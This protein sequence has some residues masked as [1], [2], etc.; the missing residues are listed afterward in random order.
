MA[1]ATGE[2]RRRHNL[3]SSGNQATTAFWSRGSIQL[4]Y[5]TQIMAGFEPASF[6]AIEVTFVFTTGESLPRRYSPKER[7][8]SSCSATAALSWRNPVFLRA[9]SRLMSSAICSNS[10]RAGNVRFV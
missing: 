5:M 3:E 6:G 2:P 10:H 7:D 1:C 8:S 9:G 4:S